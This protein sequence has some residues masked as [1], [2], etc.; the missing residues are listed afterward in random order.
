MN[1]SGIKQKSHVES[2]CI[3]VLIVCFPSC[4]F[5][6]LLD[7]LLQKRNVTCGPKDVCLK[8]VSVT[9]YVLSRDSSLMPRSKVSHVIAIGDFRITFD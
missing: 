2:V 4:S 8:S 7:M 1:K 6:L 9:D 5:D 3:V